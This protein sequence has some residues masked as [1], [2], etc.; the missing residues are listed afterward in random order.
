MFVRLL[1]LNAIFLAIFAI[2]K[3]S[4]ARP[5]PAAAALLVQLAALGANIIVLYQQDVQNY[6]TTFA[7]R[8]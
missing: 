1:V 8:F 6:L 4:G 2:R 3:A 5:M 7:K